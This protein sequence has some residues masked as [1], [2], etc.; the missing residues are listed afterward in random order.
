MESE[1]FKDIPWYEGLYQ[2][3]NLGRVKSF[4]WWKNIIR[5]LC[6]NTPWYLSCFLNKNWKLSNKLIHRLVAQAFLG[7]DINDRK[8]FV[9]HK[10]DIRTD[11]RVENLFLWSNSDNQ[12][13]SV[14]KWRR[15]WWLKQKPVNQFDMNW[16]FIKEWKSINDAERWTWA[17]NQHISKCCNN[18]LKHKTAWWFIWRYKI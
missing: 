9:C 13:D 16:N 5:K 14:N 3:S 4:L 1:I 15:K 11:N 18:I 12:K 6:K 2:V 17:R 8:M 7:L 10:N